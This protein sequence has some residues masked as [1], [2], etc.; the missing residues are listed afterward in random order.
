M[1]SSRQRRDLS[2]QIVLF[3]F[4]S[5][6]GRVEFSDFW[7]NLIFFT[8]AFVVTWFASGMVVGEVV[9]LAQS[10]R[11]SFFT[12]SFFF[13]GILTSLPEITIGITSLSMN[14]PDIFVGNL[15]GASLV[16][17]LLIIPLLAIVGNG[18]PYPKDF[19]RNQLIFTL[20]VII[21]PTLLVS[22]RRVSSW[23]GVL[24]VLLYCSLFLF[25]GKRTSLLERIGK[26]S[27][28][29]GKRISFV[30][31]KI[32]VGLVFLTLAS[33]Q[34]VMSTDYFSRLFA[35]SPFVVSLLL[36]SIGTNIPELALVAQSVFQKRKSVAFA[37]YLGSAAANTLL[38]GVF[39]L[40]YGST[41]VL[42]N[43]FVQRFIFLMIGLILFFV[44][45]RSKH[46]LSL[47]EGFVLFC[48]YLGFVGGE[49]LIER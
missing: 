6:T 41:I 21:A 32:A 36:V 11:M 29:T 13:L 39:S 31:I 7:T 46:Q 47:R 20:I 4:F 14:K 28:K 30:L 27:K 25:L 5:Y 48:L 24:L 10:L 43:H 22:D 35:W 37:N 23:E 34:I 8:G 12:L 42:P 15:I 9:R 1:R 45:A 26:T 19:S 33:R 17:F 16:L 49:L 44:F 38:F 2:D 40:I 18:I 3:V